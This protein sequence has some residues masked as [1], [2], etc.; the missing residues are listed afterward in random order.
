M[1]KVLVLGFLLVLVVFGSYLSVQVLNEDDSYVY[2][3]LRGVPAD[4]PAP[5]KRARNV[6]VELIDLDDM[7]VFDYGQFY[8]RNPGN[9]ARFPIAKR[10]EFGNAVKDSSG[11]FENRRFCVNVKR[12][13][14]C[15]GDAR[16]GTLRCF[17]DPA[18]HPSGVDCQG[19]QNIDGQG[20]YLDYMFPCM[21]SDEVIDGLVGDVEEMGFFGKLFNILRGWI[22]ALWDFIT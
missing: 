4:A 19:V 1:R 3:W 21:C 9:D 13:E 7:K 6:Y 22:K 15:V 5:F 16:E 18:W 2:L 12:V 8:L 17:D 20:Y 14:V 11:Y 10:D